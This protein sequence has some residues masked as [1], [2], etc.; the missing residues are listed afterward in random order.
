[1]AIDGLQF[2]LFNFNLCVR[3]RE[4]ALKRFITAVVNICYLR[5]SLKAVDREAMLIFRSFS[6]LIV[7]HAYSLDGSVLECMR[8]LK[9]VN[10]LSV[11]FA[12]VAF[13]NHDCGI[14]A[15]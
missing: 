7:C 4:L 13:E 2:R 5:H 1:M 9:I 8:V 15:C 6:S 3:V 12:Q 14:I 11:V 10:V